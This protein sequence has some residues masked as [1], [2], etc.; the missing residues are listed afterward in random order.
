MNEFQTGLLAIG[1][2]VVLVVIAFNKWQEQRYRR[3]SVA[4][5]KPQSV[6]VLLEPLADVPDSTAESE[7]AREHDALDAK[8]A[9]VSGV[10][11]TATSSALSRGIPNQPASTPASNPASIPIDLLVGIDSVSGVS[12]SDLHAGMLENGVARRIDMWTLIEGSR[13]KLREDGRY[14]QVNLSLQLVN[15][16]GA[17]SVLDL[18]QFAAWVG[19]VAHRCGATY[20]PLD[21]A[22]ARQAAIKLDQFC[23]EVDILIAIHVVAGSNPFPGTRIRAISEAAGLIIEADGIFRKRDDEGREL[24]R[25]ANEG[26]TLFQAELMRELVTNSVILEFDVARSPGGIHSFGKF[27]QFAGHLASGMGGKIVDDNRAP[28]SSAGFDAIA[29]ELTGVYQSMA[30]CGI[31][32]GNPESLRLFS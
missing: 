5:I 29:R 30:A 7:T 18:K 2:L 28:L 9:L 17:V 3:Q 1:T 10:F 15:R 23:G 19:A 25:L 14:Q 20:A 4:S 11:D 32:P 31:A 13:E 8:K 24:F 6:D 26:E 22:T 21:L 12:L 27:R 16:Q